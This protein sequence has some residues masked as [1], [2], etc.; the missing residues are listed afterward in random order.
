MEKNNYMKPSERIE[1]IMAENFGKNVTEDADPVRA[2]LRAI[3]DYLDE[4]WEKEQP[5]KHE[6]MVPVDESS[7]ISLSYCKKCRALSSTLY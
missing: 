4:Q 2:W 6:E 7:T 1:E 3:L 5:C